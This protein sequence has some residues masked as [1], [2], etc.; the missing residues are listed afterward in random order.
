[1]FEAKALKDAAL[2]K[3]SV[4]ADRILRGDLGVHQ[5]VYKLCIIA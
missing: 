1:M 4:D 2:K 3:A 5:V